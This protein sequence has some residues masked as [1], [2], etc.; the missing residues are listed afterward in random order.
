MADDKWLYW[1]DELGQQDAPVV[2]KKCANLGEMTRCGMPVPPGFAISIQAYERFMEETG[3]SRQIET[4]LQR[5]PQG[6][7]SYREYNEASAFIRQ[8]VEAAEM[9]LDMRDA[10]ASHY[11][12]LCRRCGVE[13]LPVAV[14]SSGPVSRPGQFETYLNIRG[15]DQ[16]VKNVIK[17]WASTFTTQAIAHRAQKGLPI[18][19]DPIG[20]AVLKVVRARAAGVGFSIDP[21]TGDGSKVVL[22][23]TWGFGESIVQGLVEPDRFIVDKASL[24]VVGKRIGLKTVQVVLEE[25]GTTKAEVPAPQQSEPSVTEEEIKQL[26]LLAKALEDHYGV[27]QDME[28]AIESDLPFPKNIFLVQTRPAGATK[29]KDAEDYIIDLMISHIFRQPKVGVPV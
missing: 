25:Q 9:P 10:I 21:V 24:A 12:E 27:P 11:D 3:V 18:A 28:W 14:R 1:L 22:E 19:S 7:R 29:K 15:A 23:S 16:V 17:C 5:F 13:N 8:L 20:V 26:A 4:Y 2:G 6:L